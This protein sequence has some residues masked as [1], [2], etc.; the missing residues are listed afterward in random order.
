MPNELSDRQKHNGVFTCIGATSHS[1]RERE[2]R[3]IIT[4]QTH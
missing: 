1:T 2:K 3:M 4:V